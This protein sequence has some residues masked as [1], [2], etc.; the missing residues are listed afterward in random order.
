LKN[1]EGFALYL[2]QHDF[3][4]GLFFEIKNGGHMG[5]VG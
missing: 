2:L 3:L 1:Q 5:K 4:F